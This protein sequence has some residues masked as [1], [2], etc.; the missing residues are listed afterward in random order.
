MWDLWG[1]TNSPLL[2]LTSSLGSWVRVHNITST[3]SGSWVSSITPTHN[4]TQSWAKAG[5]NTIYNI[6]VG[7]ATQKC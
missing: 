6:F 4:P 7:S 1:V 5:S 3:D 2:A